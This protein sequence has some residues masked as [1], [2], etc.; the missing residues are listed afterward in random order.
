MKTDDMSYIQSD[1]I[2]YNYWKLF[3]ISIHKSNK[4]QMIGAPSS[5]NLIKS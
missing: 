5:I 4:K 1:Q 2:K 3:I